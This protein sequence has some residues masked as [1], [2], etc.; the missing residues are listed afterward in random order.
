HHGANGK[1]WLF[2]GERNQKSDYFYKT[3]WNAHKNLQIHTAFSRDQEEKVYVQ[4]K[5]LENA[6]EIY[7]WLKKGAHLYVCGDAKV[8]AKDVR[9]TLLQII[10]SQG[11]LSEDEAK[12]YLKALKKE[13]R[14][15]LDVY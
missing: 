10:G 7:D 6:A 9:K 2:F 11:N 15:L 14:Y 12:T 4:H 8:M 5:L 13:G 1:H 3:E